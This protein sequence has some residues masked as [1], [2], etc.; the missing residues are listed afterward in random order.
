MIECCPECASSRIELQGPGG[1]TGP[2]SEATKRYRCSDCRNQFDKTDSR[3][4]ESSR[5]AGRSGITKKL[6]DADP[7]DWP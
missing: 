1:F 6:M 4:P 5:N 3:K 7:E 2:K